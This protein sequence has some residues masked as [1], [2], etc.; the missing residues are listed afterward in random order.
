MTSNKADEGTETVVDS[1]P[2]FDFDAHQRVAADQYSAVRS[3]YDA[4]ANAIQHVITACI[5]NAGLTVHSV[6]AR[7]KTVESFRAK[8]GRPSDTDPGQPRYPM[9]LDQITDLAGVR[10]ITYFPGSV[11]SIG[12]IIAKNFHV[13]ETV[14][15]TARAQT[16][17]RL[18]YLSVHYF[19][20][21]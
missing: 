8:A 2:E 7:A 18:G 3:A 9:P 4:L 17:G 6:Q 21:L 16:T 12:E 1:R 11:A 5:K 14:D 13:I 20:Q 19:E 10:V 15:H